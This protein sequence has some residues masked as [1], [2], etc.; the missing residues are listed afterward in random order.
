M[1]LLKEKEKSKKIVIKYFTC[2]FIKQIGLLDTVIKLKRILFY[3]SQSSYEIGIIYIL[4]FSVKEMP[5]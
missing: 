4:S 5:T 2:K 1:W 3:S